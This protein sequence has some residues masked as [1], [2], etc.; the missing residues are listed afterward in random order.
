MIFDV[1]QSL[2]WYIHN[3][4]LNAEVTGKNAS[5][6]F[7]ELSI[8][9]NIP[10]SNEESEKILQLFESDNLK[11]LQDV[12]KADQKEIEDLKKKNGFSVF[13]NGRKE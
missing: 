3:F 7:N 11:Q 9:N 6:L 4:L 12:L 8:P 2:Y 13:Q 5:H 10:V 1:N